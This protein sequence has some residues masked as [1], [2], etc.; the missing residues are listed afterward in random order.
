MKGLLLLADGFEDSE[1]LTTRDILTRAGIEVVTSSI[2]TSKDVTS[3]FG[4]HLLSD[5]T[6]NE[7]NPSEYDF[8]VLPGGGKGTTN[9]KASKDVDRIIDIFVSQNKLIAAICAAPSL[10][11][12]KG[13]LKDKHYTCF[14]GCNEG[15]GIFTGSEVEV[16]G[17]FIT[18][19][20]M[21]YSIPFALE[22]INK[23]LGKE[24]V[25]NVLIGLK[26]QVAK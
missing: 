22:I 4:I 20:S 26:G 3:S 1:G 24:V 6:I 17:N 13:L 15:E 18:A 5:I 10:L 12:R 23:L 11:G 7:V 25:N 8:I 2:K 19:R 9:L 16:D 14:R 21:M